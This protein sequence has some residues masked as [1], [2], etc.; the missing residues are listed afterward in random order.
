MKERLINE[1]MFRATIKIVTDC[2]FMEFNSLMLSRHGTQL[3]YSWDQPFSLE[4][5][6]DAY[7]FHIISANGEDE[8][9]YIWIYK[10]DIYL[11][12]HEVHHLTHDILFTR[13]ILCS[14]GTEEIF[15]YL[16]GRLMELI[17][18]GGIYV[19]GVKS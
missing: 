17:L 6:A 19:S 10:V 16:M 15:A 18:E 12:T 9:F 7:Q 11:L 8:L 14:Y 1:S 5:G 13:G 2:S 4:D 3:L